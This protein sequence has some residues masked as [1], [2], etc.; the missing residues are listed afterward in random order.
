MTHTPDAFHEPAG[1]NV[2]ADP[3]ATGIRG[4]NPYT[5]P[6]HTG[7]PDDNLY[8]HPTAEDETGNI[9]ADPGDTS[10]MRS[11]DQINAGIFEGEDP[12]DV[13]ADAVVTDEVEETVVED[14][15]F[16]S[17]DYGN[18]VHAPAD[19]DVATY[20][21][22]VTEA[23]EFGVARDEQVDAFGDEVDDLGNPL[24]PIPPVPPRF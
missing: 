22:T 20:D 10:H 3:D 16:D 21:P 2:Y 12:D 5:D 9:Y 8:T 18:V 1:D 24:P 11:T 23:D 6:D 17:P 15:V 13:H 7:V 14:E 4:D 19:D